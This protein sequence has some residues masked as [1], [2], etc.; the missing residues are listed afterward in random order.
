VLK[1]LEIGDFPPNTLEV[2][3]RDFLRLPACEAAFA[4]QAQERT[5]FIDGEAERT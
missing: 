5:Y 3:E 2:T 4:C 1:L